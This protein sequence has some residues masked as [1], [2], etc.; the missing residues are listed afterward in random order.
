MVAAWVAWSDFPMKWDG[1]GMGLAW[2]KKSHPTHR[3]Q[4]GWTKLIKQ[5]VMKKVY[6][7]LPL[8]LIGGGS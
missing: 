1:I 8:S 6:I 2:D 5:I 4:S 7:M 3:G